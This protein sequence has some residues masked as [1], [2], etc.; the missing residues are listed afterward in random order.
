MKPAIP[1]WQRR[2]YFPVSPTTRA[3]GG[4]GRTLP[5]LTNSLY[6]NKKTYVSQQEQ[7]D[8]GDPTGAAFVNTRV[9]RY[10]DV[11][12]MAAECANEIG[13]AANDS[14]AEAWLE[15]IRAR[16]RRVTTAVLPY[17]QYQNQAQF[18]AA[19]KHERRV[20]FGME[21]ERFYDLVRWG[22]AQ[23]ALAGYLPKNEYY[24]IPDSGLIRKSETGAESELLIRLMIVD[25][26]RK[27]VK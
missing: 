20:E 14:A 21:M 27:P 4:Y 8:A 25:L 18:R 16:A 22:D 24:P 23:S 5:P 10:A 26:K 15:M 1:E 2:Y 6:W 13:G 11:I 9:F 19:I 3:N 12:L 17:I 7:L